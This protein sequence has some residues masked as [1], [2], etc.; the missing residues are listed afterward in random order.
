LKF[1]K[2]AVGK[3]GWYEGEVSVEDNVY[4]GV[5]HAFSEGMFR[6]TVRFV[7]DTLAGASNRVTSK[8]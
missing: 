5:G 2:T 3:G 4:E 7:G 6:D 1:L 8:M